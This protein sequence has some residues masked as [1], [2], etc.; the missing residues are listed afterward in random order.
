MAYEI[1]EPLLRSG[2]GNTGDNPQRTY[3]YGVRGSEP[4]DTAEG[5][6]AAVMAAAAS[7]QDGMPMTGSR[8]ESLGGWVWLVEVEYRPSSRQI[9]PLPVPGDPNRRS[10]TTLGATQN[11]KRSIETMFADAVPPFDV[12]PDFGGLINV[13]DSGVDGVDITVPDWR[14]TVIRYMTTAQIEAPGFK[15]AVFGL[16]GKVNNA[17]YMGFAAGELLY[18]GAQADQRNADAVWE[19]THQFQARPNRTGIVINGAE[20]F[21]AEGW[22]LVWVRT[23]PQDQDDAIAIVPAAFYVERVYERGDFSALGL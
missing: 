1:S 9:K 6:Q 23:A 13:T 20:P 17:T 5:A 12:V 4:T 19:V 21:D 16:T 10:W 8:V 18:L 2:D 7:T 11:I 15:A 3:I 14:E 22:D